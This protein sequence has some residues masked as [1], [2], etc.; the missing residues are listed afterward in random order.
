MWN[1][2]VER[3][4]EIWRT[5][6]MGRKYFEF[7][8]TAAYFSSELRIYVYINLRMIYTKKNVLYNVYIYSPILSIFFL[9]I[10]SLRA[11]LCENHSFYNIDQF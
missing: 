4:A 6:T 1:N 9:F 8:F 2:F 5:R 3:F 10:Y 11:Y 7:P